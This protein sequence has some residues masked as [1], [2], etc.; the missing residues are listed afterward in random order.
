LPTGLVALHGSLGFVMTQAVMW[1]RTGHSEQQILKAAHWLSKHRRKL[2]C[3][4]VPAVIVT[5][6]VALIIFISVDSGERCESFCASPCRELS[7][8]LQECDGCALQD[9]PRQRMCPGGWCCKD[10]DCRDRSDAVPCQGN[11]T[12]CADGNKC[13]PAA[14]DWPETS[15][16]DDHDDH[17][18]G[19]D[20]YDLANLS[21]VFLGLTL[22]MVVIVFGC[23]ECAGCARKLVRRLCQP[24]CFRQRWSDQEGID[25]S[26]RGQ[27]WTRK[28]LI[29]AV[30][31]IVLLS[32]PQGGTP[33][34]GGSTWNLLAGDRGSTASCEDLAPQCK[35]WE[36]CCP[37]ADG[38]GASCGKA[39]C[40][41]N[42]T[43]P[44]TGEW[45]GQY[46]PVR[47]HSTL[48][49]CTP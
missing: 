27:A 34:F 30:L 6:L 45:T 10:C 13:C 38:L 11:G 44:C 23:A 39:D 19:P 3:A 1:L 31:T 20:L 49:Q 5:L 22:V 21:V 32:A 48:L 26:L 4:L 41:S 2:Y 16:D 25:D 17:D 37:G 43:G 42:R 33:T 9:P 15:E 12:K 7:G 18:E 14:D 29:V 40:A 28:A 47:S 36:S 35:G 8:A 24:R 46:C